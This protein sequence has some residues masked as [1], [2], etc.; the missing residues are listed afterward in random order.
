[1]KAIILAAGRG[2][3]LGEAAGGLPKCL[4]Q[5]GGKTLLQRHIEILNNLGVERIFIVTG[6]E[7]DQVFEAL[8]D[9]GSRAPVE[10]LST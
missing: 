7:R 4:L 3:R 9:L 10:V 2:E 5:Y 6:Y 1:M 8:H